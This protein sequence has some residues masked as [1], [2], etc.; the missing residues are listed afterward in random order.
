LNAGGYHASVDYQTPDD[1]IWP[2]LIIP[3]A[4]VLA[5]FAVRFL[6]SGKNRQVSKIDA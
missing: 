4:I 6:R 5:V 2:C 1:A 3:T